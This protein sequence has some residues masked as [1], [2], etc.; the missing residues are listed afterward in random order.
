MNNETLNNT[1]PDRLWLTAVGMLLVI[2]ISIT[3]PGTLTTVYGFLVVLL[4]VWQEKNSSFM[5]TLGFKKADRNTISLFVKAPFVAA[6]MVMVYVLVLMPLVVSIT[7]KPLDLSVFESFKGDLITTLVA[8]PLVWLMAAFGEE[9][10]FR[11]FLMTRFSRI[12]GESRP[13]LIINVLIMGSTFGYAH[14]YQGISGQILSGIT[15]MVLAIVFYRMKNNLWFCIAVHG[16]FDTIALLL[17]Y[18]GVG[19]A[20]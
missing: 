16:W 17:F 20:L 1:K 10:V 6:L 7:G 8:L 4:V 19:D 9:I 13:S 18:F 12:F 15:G 5:A 11:G 14:G 2:A 3:G